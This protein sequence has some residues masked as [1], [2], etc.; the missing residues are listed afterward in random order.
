MINVNRTYTRSSNKTREGPLSLNKDVGF[1]PSICWVY[2]LSYADAN[3]IN[4]SDRGHFLIVARKLYLFIVA[5]AKRSQI[6][7]RERA[8]REEL[9]SVCEGVCRAQHTINKN[10]KSTYTYKIK[11]YC[12]GIRLWRNSATEWAGWA[13]SWRSDARARAHSVN[14]GGGLYMRYFFHKFIY[15]YL[16]CTKYTFLS[17]VC[18]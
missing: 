14:C 16:I 3:E 4:N 11:Y 17:Y 1:F 15:V 6:F 2:N 18:I 7:V 12:I 13:L 5:I 9:F 8:A 10:N